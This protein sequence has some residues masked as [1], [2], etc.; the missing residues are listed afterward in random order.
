MKHTVTKRERI[1]GVP[2]HDKIMTSIANCIEKLG[3]EKCTMDDFASAVGISRIS[4][5]RTYGNKTKLIDS[6]LAY[7]ANQFN[8][9][10]GLKMSNCRNLE[11][12]L[13]LYFVTTTRSAVKDKTIRFLIDSQYV[14]KVL[15]SEKGSLM[16]APVETLWAPLIAKF[17][18]PDSNIN[19][20][21]KKEIINWIL[22]MQASLSR[23]AIESKCADSD[24]IAM[25]RNFILPAFASPIASL[26]KP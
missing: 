4:L 25:V 1:G 16:R 7:R 13:I 18:E 22:I 10:I 23:V 20:I 5:Y 6:V 24:I 21:D 17:S 3:L 14:F 8:Q 19:T 2:G 12:A 11:D 9:K 26:N 15:Y